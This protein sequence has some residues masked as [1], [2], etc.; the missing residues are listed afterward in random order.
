[1]RRIMLIGALLGATLLASGCAQMQKFEDSIKAALTVYE[2]VTTAT[3]PATTIVVTATAFNGVKSV[4]TTYLRFCKDNLSQPVC[5]ADNRRSVIK[6]V[7]VGT[8]A[9][10]ALEPYIV[11][12]GAG[13]G[14]VYNVMVDAINNLN[15]L[16]IAHTGG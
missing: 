12:G 16:P 15:A 4:A 5:S 6:W 13:P 7:R 10:N 14:D 1:M 2:R 9:R 8:S 3:V 11:T